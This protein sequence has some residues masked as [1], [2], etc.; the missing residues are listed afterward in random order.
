ML[1]GLEALRSTLFIH[2]YI[3]IQD[4]INKNKFSLIITHGAESFLR[5][6]QC[7]A[8]Q[9]LPKILRNPKF[10]YRVHRSHELFLIL[11]QINPIH[12]IP[13]YLPSSIFPSGFPTN[14]LYAFFSHPF[15]LHSLGR[16]NHLLFFH[17]KLCLRYDKEKKMLVCTHKEDKAVQ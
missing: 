17:Y 12:I 7:A 8:T 9:E 10:Q 14:I 4:S 6:R 16:I 13:S 15:V 5:S 2:F 3:I 11:S 1:Y